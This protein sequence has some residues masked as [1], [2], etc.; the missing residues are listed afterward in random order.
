MYPPPP[1]GEC[2]NLNRP[3]SWSAGGFGFTVSNFTV[4]VG[5]VVFS[6]SNQLL[7]V[8]RFDQPSEF[9]LPSP[10]RR[11]MGRRATT[12]TEDDREQQR[13]LNIGCTLIQNRK[14]LPHICW[15][16]RY[17]PEICKFKF[18]NCKSVLNPSKQTNRKQFVCLTF[19][20]AEVFHSFCAVLA[21]VRLVMALNIVTIPWLTLH[22]L[23]LLPSL[24]FFFFA[25]TEREWPSSL[26]ACFHTWDKQKDQ[27]IRS[28]ERVGDGERETGWWWR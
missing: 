10:N 8:K 16:C 12:E 28:W 11:T 6:H 13:G 15:F 24:S 26:H 9:Y 17:R 25:T 4:L 2:W 23:H 27:E 18:N 5:C 19:A 7:S 14:L 3:A 1:T 20:E 22:L 21:F